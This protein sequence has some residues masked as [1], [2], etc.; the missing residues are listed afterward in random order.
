[1][2]PII[3]GDDTK[4]TRMTPMGEGDVFGSMINNDYQNVL[5]TNIIL[6]AQI[7]LNNNVKL[8]FSVFFAK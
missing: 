2:K 6:C 8:W 7:I 5:T 1:M 4:K 3:G